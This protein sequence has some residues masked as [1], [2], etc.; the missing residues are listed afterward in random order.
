MKKPKV[1]LNSEK[2]EYTLRWSEHCIPSTPVGLVRAGVVLDP[3][4]PVRCEPA[5]GVFKLDSF[6]VA[7]SALGFVSVFA[8]TRAVTITR[9]LK[10][11]LPWPES[12]RIQLDTFSNL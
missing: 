9:T 2:I 8:G 10:Q 11:W 4:H 7:L 3:Y 12:G 6:L 1:T 5:L